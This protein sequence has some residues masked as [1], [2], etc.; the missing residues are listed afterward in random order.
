MTSVASPSDRVLERL[1]ALHPKKIDLSLGRMERLLGLLGNPE[2]KL[3]PTF[4]IAGTNGKGSTAAYLRAMLEAAGKRVH[5]Y[6]SPHLVRFAE[7]IR[8]AGKIIDEDALIEVLETCER[9]NG[10]DPITFFEVTTAAAFLA[11][12]QTPADALI[13]EVG[14]GGR[15]D[16]TNVIDR[17]L[18]TAITP[19]SMDHEQFLGDTITLIATE[20]AGIAKP[21]CPLVLGPQTGEALKVFAETAAKIGA[22]LLPQDTAWRVRDDG[23]HFIYEDQNGSLRLAR[24]NLNGPHQIMNAGLA[25]ACLRAQNLFTLSAGEMSAGVSHAVWPARLQEIT[26]AAG[27]EGFPPG[28]RIW[29]DGG[30]NPAAGE[31]LSHAFGG[32]KLP[33][34]LITGMLA[35]KDAAGFFKPFAAR[36]A[37][38]FA[39]DIAGEDC[40]PATELAGFASNAGLIAEV[41]GN[42]G[43][44]LERIKKSL[45]TDQPAHIL[46]CGSLYLA[47]QVLRRTGLLPT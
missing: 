19:V 24:P 45:P 41:A 9:V 33:L 46:I 20:K 15:L 11:F 27:L 47:G 28:S 43:A 42:F 13:L 12:S 16:A 31:I 25:V 2:R 5:V 40:H 36:A 30:H 6:T 22:V 38:V 29:L 39:I 32:D 1:T 4:H 14:L 21:G 7:R 10:P 17:P 3:P 44:A 26:G 35:N 34:Y 18:V 37:K 23:D 8:L